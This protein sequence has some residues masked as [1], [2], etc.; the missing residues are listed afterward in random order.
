MDVPLSIIEF[1]VI[2]KFSDE[3][4]S[5][6]FLSQ[7]IHGLIEWTFRYILM[8]L[9][10]SITKLVQFIHGASYKRQITPPLAWI[11]IA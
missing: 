5:P 4:F 3:P 10:F 6:W 11:H 8:N 2:S 7:A 1:K 9:E